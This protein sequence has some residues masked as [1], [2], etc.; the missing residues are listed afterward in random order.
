[1]EAHWTSTFN[2]RQSVSSLSLASHG[3]SPTTSSIA[4][5]SLASLP[6]RRAVRIG[7]RVDLPLG[8]GVIC[9]VAA[10]QDRILVLL[11][12]SR[13][14]DSLFVLEGLDSPRLPQILILDVGDA[15]QFTSAPSLIGDDVSS[16]LSGGD[17][18][19]SEVSRED[20]TLKLSS[21]V[22]CFGMGIG[23]FC[24]LFLVDC[25]KSDSL[26]RLPQANLR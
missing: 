22:G 20:V 4:N 2:D 11:Y 9:G 12:P 6:Q 14:M 17:E 16:I 10:H 24:L 19:F 26:K 15:L 7:C 1:M 8:T 3:S 13:S 5:A 21:S 25:L 18:T 23:G